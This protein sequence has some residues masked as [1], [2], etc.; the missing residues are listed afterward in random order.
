[1]EGANAACVV[2]SEQLEEGCG[3]E[4]GVG[5]VKELPVRDDDDAALLGGLPLV[6][7]WQASWWYQAWP[8]SW[9][10]SRNG[11][12]GRRSSGA[13]R[14]SVRIEDSQQRVH[15]TVTSSTLTL[16]ASSSPTH[17]PDRKSVV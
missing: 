12:F 4:E 14:T 17:S 3:D 13:E 7:S 8:S 6:A 1:M 11:G 5:A 16:L 9:R 2:E 10:S 15:A